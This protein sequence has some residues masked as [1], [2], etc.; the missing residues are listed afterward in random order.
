MY[1]NDFDNLHIYLSSR[2]NTGNWS[3]SIEYAKELSGLWNA[4]G[5]SFLSSIS[6]NATF[7]LAIGDKL[8]FNGQACKVVQIVNDNLIRVDKDFSIVLSQKLFSLSESNYHLLF[9]L[10]KNQKKAY[11]TANTFVKNSG[12]WAIP[13]PETIKATL[14][15]FEY[16]LW[17]FLTSGVNEAAQD[18]NSGILEKKIDVLQWKYD[19]DFVGSMIPGS[20]ESISYLKQ[21][22]TG[23]VG[24]LGGSFLI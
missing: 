18:L 8:S 19:K 24:N 7:D 21:Y 17:I 2:F 10:N 9:E 15:I 23:Q 13:N 22:E 20:Q 11:D 6:G 5:T 4:S 12:I 3:G 16:T 14:G 1:S